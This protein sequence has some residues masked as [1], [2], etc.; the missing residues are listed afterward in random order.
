MVSQPGQIFIGRQR[1]LETLTAALEDALEGRGR[2]VML[3]GE[4]GIGKTRT[5]QE[6]AS[7]AQD[8]GVRILWGWCY[9]QRGAPAYWPWLQALR[10]YIQQS[11]PD[12]LRLMMGLGAADIAEIVPEI[13]LI[14]PD[15]TPPPTLEPEEARFRLFDSIVAFLKRAAQSEPLVLVLDDLHWADKPSLLLLEFMIRQI[16][17]SRI[18]VVGCYRDTELTRQHPLPD[19]LAQL[20]REPIFKRESLRG[21][22]HDDSDRFIKESTGTSPPQELLDTVYDHTEGNPFFTAEVIR[23][24]AEEGELDVHLAGLPQAIR[25]PDGVREVIGQRLNR[26]S[27]HCNQA[28]T[29]ASVI[30]RE[31]AFALLRRLDEE[32]PEDRLL[33]AVDEAV[34]ARLIEEVPGEIDHYRFNHALIQQS[35]SDEMTT[36]RRVRLHARI[37][38]ALEEL[39][40]ENIEEHASELAYHFTEAEAANGP[41]KMVRYSMLAGERALAAYAHE[42]A[43]FHFQRALAAKGVALDGSAPAPD[44]IA[45]DLLLGLGRAQIA[46]LP[47]TRE[48]VTN[49]TRAFEQYVSAGDVERAVVIAEYPLPPIPG[50]VTGIGQLIKRAL[51]LVPPDSLQAGRLQASYSR[52]KGLEEGDYEAACQAY[53]VALAI[54]R[55]NSDASLELQT[56]SFACDVDGFHMRWPKALENGL[57]AV[58]LASRIDNPRAELLAHVWCFVP[59]AIGGNLKEAA[60]H[61]AAMLPLAARLRHHYYWARAYFAA[62]LASSLAGDFN[63]A[64]EYCDR[65]LATAPKDSRL[66]Y[67]RALLEYELGNYDEGDAYLER[68]L[69][70]ASQS[71]PGPNLERSILAVIIPMVIRITGISEHAGIAEESN[72]VILASSTSTPVVTAFGR[73]G[74]SLLS[75]YR[76][77]FDTAA[78]QYTALAGSRDVE[79]SWIF[80]FPAGRLLGLLAQAAGQVDEAAAHFEDC[81]IFCRKGGFKPALAWTCYD[82]ADALLNPSTSAAPSRLSASGR[83]TAQA[84]EKSRIKAMF[85]LDEA[86]TIS[87]GLSMRPLTDRVVA[88]QELAAA[89]LGPSPTYPDGLTNREVEILRLVA[90]GSSNREIGV[91]LVL[92]TRTVERH[93][94][95]IYGKIG[96]R[97]RADATSYALGHGLLDQK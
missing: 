61:S 21:L 95:N 76:R 47:T 83:S 30:G 88:L 40:G 36:S 32:S 72:R 19:T 24:L 37:G 28:M 52:V 70:V 3:V 55:Q 4:P 62:S 49:F 20:S 43:V 16:A 22:S 81:L 46:M 94:T 90:S 57:R 29:I 92:S 41:E 96:A 15:L 54:A 89:Q 65:G 50:Y 79:L 68:C 31:F 75:T 86:L 26:L 2:L 71:S 53:D 25:I 51:A 80:G 5:A 44:R 56:L 18:L 48:A 84:K 9:E 97:R 85:L 8:R 7:R 39:Y 14:V 1:E 38:E 66:L 59:L 60:S 73:I 10:S 34:A 58:E 63:T 74:S 45:A 67:A 93:I 17:D 33:E 42:D 13:N 87:S 69:E 27:S 23:L 82:Y 91:E 77:D 6:L 78:I 11:D 64:R 35:L 12:S